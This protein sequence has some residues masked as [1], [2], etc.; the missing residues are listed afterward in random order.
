[1]NIHAPA[2]LFSAIRLSFR[3]V[4]FLLFLLM[5]ACSSSQTPEQEVQEYVRTA[6]KSFENKD[7]GDLKKLISKEYRDKRDLRRGDITRILAG[8]F[9]RDRKTFIL[10]NLEE[11]RFTNGD[12]TA[13][14]RLL[15]ALSS[16]PLSANDLQLL[17]ADCYLL[18]G[19][20]QKNG[21]WLLTIAE[22][23]RMSVDECVNSFN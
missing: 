8:Y 4:M 7:A 15:A 20:L 22:L 23:Q 2:C 21:D 11:V 6:E 13:D 14:F 3:I 1:M 5:S 12:A 17:D 18:T 9:L 10:S 16:K 19:T